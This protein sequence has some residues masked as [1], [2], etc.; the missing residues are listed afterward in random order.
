VFEGLTPSVGRRSWLGQ[1]RF[2]LLIVLTLVLLVA[3]LVGWRSP[4]AWFRWGLVVRSCPDGRPVPMLELGASDMRRG[5]TGR[6]TLL[7]TALLPP[8]GLGEPRELP[9]H[10][11]QPFVELVDA[12]GERWT[13]E[14]VKGWSEVKTGRW[15]VEVRLPELPDGDYRLVAHADTPMGRASAEVPLGFYAPAIV[16]LA[17]DRPLYEPGQVIRFRAVALRLADLTPMDGRPGRFVMRDPD[18]VVLLDERVPAGLYGVAASDLPLSV[19]ASVG[20]YELAYHSGDAVDHVDVRVEPFQLPRFAVDLRGD[21]SWYAP[22]DGPRIEGSLRYHSGAPVRGAQLEVRVVSEDGGWPLPT[23]WRATRRLVS[24]GD[25]SF[26]LPLEAVPDDIHGLASARVELVATD[27]AGERV[28]ASLPLRLSADAIAVQAETEMGNG[29]VPDLN[30][31][32]YLRVT[33]PDGLPLGGV[34]LGISRA[35]ESELEAVH[36]RTD[37]DGVAALQLDPGQPGSVLVP[38]APV[39]PPLPTEHSL[40]HREHADDLYNP[41]VVSIDERV[42]LDAWSPALEPCADL[43]PTGQAAKVRLVVELNVTGGVVEVLDDGRDLDRCVAGR[44]RGLRGFPGAPRLYDLMWKLD[45]SP[46]AQ[47]ELVALDGAPSTPLAVR[48]ALDEAARRARPCVLDRSATT[49]L[50]LFLAWRGRQGSDRLELRWEPSPGVGGA[51]RASDL[52]CVRRAVGQPTLSEALDR[53]YL[54]SA[55]FRVV[56]DPAQRVTTRSATVRS[57]YEL[58]VRATRG[59][60]RVGDTTLVLSPGRAPKLRLRPEQPVL[61]AGSPVHIRLLRGPG[62]DGELPDPSVPVPMELG[63]AEYCELLYDPDAN[64]LVGML[65]DDP[66]LHGLLSVSWGGARAV[67]M[68]PRPSALGLAITPERDLLRPGELARLDLQTAV[69]GAPS[70]AAVSLFGVDQA[71]GQLA[72]LLGP[73]DFGRVTV[74]ATTRGSAFG[75]FDARDL[76][77]GAIRGEHAVLATLL[78]MNQLPRTHRQETFAWGNGASIFDPEVVLTEAFYALLGRAMREVARWEE[79]TPAGVMLSLEITAALWGRA[80]EHQHDAGLPCTDAFGIPLTLDRLPDDLLRLTDPRWLVSDARRLP[81]DVQD[82]VGWV[83]LE[84]S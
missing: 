14:L 52:A 64:A 45:A 22:G 43:V 55:R 28:T 20:D 3:L 71:L 17:T 32:V 34:D 80:L 41:M 12:A 27:A 61:V 24:D 15:E 65:P 67:I 54:G 1:R 47:L 56:P 70:P 23:P 49:A 59:D 33:T 74:Q 5:E 46:G 16:H 35:W 7:A 11:V 76:L 18:G 19:N 50:P 77:T 26:E 51:W 69:D 39:R 72:P 44:V 57:G 37:A 36:A 53:G 78:R 66:E 48:T 6:V 38:P 8:A 29:L 83:R 63:G 62:F 4:T 68:V 58:R 13:V 40:V 60:V 84:G 79:E 31:R 42:A 73:D 30:N 75:V 81:E 25:G 2:A 21:R 10:R 82:W 9:L